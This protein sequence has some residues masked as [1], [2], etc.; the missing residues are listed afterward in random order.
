V[1]IYQS[2]KPLLHQGWAPNRHLSPIPVLDGAQ[3]AEVPPQ[4]Y[5]KISSLCTTRKSDGD[6]RHCTLLQWPKQT[7]LAADFC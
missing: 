5:L 4:L 3:H 2:F 6:S 7:F 1:H